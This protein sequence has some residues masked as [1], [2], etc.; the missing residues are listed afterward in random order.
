VR[1][2]SFL[3]KRSN[4]WIL[5]LGALLVLLLGAIDVLTG[6]EISFSVFYLLPI[7]L[8]TWLIGR[9]AGV[10][11]SVASAITWLASDYLAGHSYFHPLVPYWNMAVRLSFFL[12]IT[13]LL[14]ELRTRLQRERHLARTDSLTNVANRRYFY[15]LAEMEIARALRYEHPL[16]IAYID[17]NNF[18]HV[19]DQRGHAAGD[20][21]LCLVANTI[22]SNLRS[23]D[24][25]ARMGGDEFA[26]LLPET[27]S[28]YAKETLARV[29]NVLLE[30]AGENEPSVTFSIGASTF[31]RPPDSVDEML[32]SVDGLMYAA[33]HSGENIIRHEV[34]H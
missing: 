29:R 15:D 14:S 17:I 10:S 34:Y 21:L 3:R 31:L 27:G 12:I 5:A 33:K 19:N 22:Q 23:V 11:I 18:K 26:I 4:P 13:W 7:L 6:R 28:E 25:V 9:W 20:A 24:V 2:G 32:K 8:V 16:S 1:V 30:A